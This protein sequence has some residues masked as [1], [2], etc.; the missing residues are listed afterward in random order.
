M[1]DAVLDGGIVAFSTFMRG[2]SHPI[3][4]ALTLEL[5]ELAHEFGPSR[6]FQVLRDEIRTLPEDGRPL[7]HFLARRLPAV[8]A[9]G[10][11]DYDGN[12]SQ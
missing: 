6:G 5:G 8:V 7:S 11:S 4:P 3:N 9:N 2:A 1:R 12:E 10:N